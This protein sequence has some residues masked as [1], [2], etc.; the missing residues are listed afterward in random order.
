VRGN[1]QDVER[2]DRHEFESVLVWCGEVQAARAGG[3]A[4]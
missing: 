1:G 2:C 4:K 3:V